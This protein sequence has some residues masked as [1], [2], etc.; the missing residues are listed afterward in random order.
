MS[1][2]TKIKIL[3]SHIAESNAPTPQNPS[4]RISPPEGRR[5]RRSWCNRHHLSHHDH[6]HSNIIRGF[7]SLFLL[8]RQGRTREWL[9]GVQLGFGFWCWALESA[10]GISRLRV[11][12]TSTL[13]VALPADSASIL[14][15]AVINNNSYLVVAMG[16]S[17]VCPLEVICPIYVPYDMTEALLVV[18]GC[19]GV[20]PSTVN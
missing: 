19:R 13:T 5:R 1:V 4:F 15:T 2:P 14:G 16:L 8:C 20:I 3:P 17:H 11:R 6:Q 18:V 12:E 7:P 9:P 10:R